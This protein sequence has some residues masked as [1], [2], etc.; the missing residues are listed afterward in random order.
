MSSAAI[1]VPGAFGITLK[2]PKKKKTVQSP[3]KACRVPN[4]KQLYDPNIPA[5]KMFYAT[6]SLAQQDYRSYCPIHAA[7][8]IDDGGV[9][10]MA[11]ESSISCTEMSELPI[12]RTPG[13]GA[14]SRTGQIGKQRPVMPLSPRTSISSSRN[15]I[16][17]ASTARKSSDDLLPPQPE[18]IKQPQWKEKPAKTTFSFGHI[19]D[20]SEGGGDSTAR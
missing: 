12:K 4:C 16:L 8:A 10:S 5:N 20:D 9:A 18:V 19:G 1:F 2:R 3:M 13:F 7:M 15:S 11:K 6:L 14:S 17:S